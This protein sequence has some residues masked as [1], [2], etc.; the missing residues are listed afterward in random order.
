MRHL[1]F[2]LL[3]FVTGCLGA[4]ADDVYKCT[5][6]S[7]AVAYQDHACANGDDATTIH[8]LPPPEQPPAPPAPAPDDQAAAQEPMP[9]TAP[10]DVAAAPQPPQMFLCTRAEDGTQYMSNDGAPQPR[11]V[12]GGVLGIP[13][14]SLADAY[15]KGG[16]GVSAP[17][18]RKIPVDKSPQASAAADYVTVQDQCVPASTETTCQYLRAEYDKVHGKLRR[19]FKDEQAILQP[20]L[21]DL[22]ARLSGC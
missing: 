20:Q 6:P 7:G 12:P 2:I 13:G 15:G 5:S 11:L 9:D 19:A 10:A 1:S 22:D 4:R 17:G 18:V 16:I 3:L 14:K 21:D 8:L